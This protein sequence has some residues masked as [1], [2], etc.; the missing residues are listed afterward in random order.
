MPTNNNFNISEYCE[1]GYKLVIIMNYE[2]LRML[3]FLGMDR[4]KPLY[5][6]YKNYEKEFIS[7]YVK[8]VIEIEHTKENYHFENIKKIIEFFKVDYPKKYKNIT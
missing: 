6:N 7:E 1:D 5:Q 8:Q 3:R 2:N 4:S